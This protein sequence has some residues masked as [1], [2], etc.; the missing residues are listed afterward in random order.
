MLLLLLAKT[1]ALAALLSTKLSLG[2]Q[3]LSIRMPDIRPDYPEQY[4]CT[5]HRLP[6]DERGLYITAFQ[7]QADASRVHHMLVYGCRMPG[8]VE[9]DSPRLVWDCGEMHTA[10][11]KYG[12][13]YLQGP[14]CQG[15][16]VHMIYGWAL[17][18]PALTLPKSVGFKIGEP[19]SGIHYLVLQVHYGHAHAFQHNPGL[20]DN[21]GLILGLEPNEP[22]S[23]ITRQAGVLLMVSL[24]QVERGKSKHEIWCDLNDDI[25]IHP[26]RYRVHTH[27]LGTRVLGAKLHHAA[28]SIDDFQLVNTK[29]KAARRDA[30]IGIGDPQKPQMFYPVEDQDLTLRKGDKVYASCEFNNNQSRVINIGPTA[31]DE[32]CNFYMMYWTE[33]PRLLSEGTC[34]GRNPRSLLASL[35]SLWY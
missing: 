3:E 28:K 12:E 14:V 2:S 16:D 9:R 32:M 20:T 30:W 23:G 21:S 4:L 11:D 17:D 27:K 25:E 26:F 8:V 34:Y 19:S 31:E 33:S 22:E 13:S 35:Q 24:G 10:R 29:P 5:A 6:A 1:V 18:A 7:P 15:A